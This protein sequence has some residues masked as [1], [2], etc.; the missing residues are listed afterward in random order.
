MRASD[1]SGGLV[2]RGVRWDLSELYVGPD[3]PRLREHLEEAGRLAEELARRF[4]GRIATGEAR[5]EDLAEALVLYERIVERGTR[6]GFYA[7]LLFA[8]DTEND[9]ARQLDAWAREG[10]ADVRERTLFLELE[11]Q[12]M[13]DERLRDMLGSTRLAR[14]R[15]YLETCVRHRPHTLTEA[16]ERILNRKALTS[17]DAFVQLYDELAGSL[18]FELEVDGE[19]RTLTD[20]EMMA[21]LHHRDATVRRRALE[22]YLETW[23]HHELVLTSTFNNLLLDHRIESDLRRFPTPIAQRHLENDVDPAV[24]EAMLDSVERHYGDVQRYFRLK[25]RLLGIAEP[26]VSD[27]YAPVDAGE[28]KIP[29][30]EAR[31]LVLDAFA[32]F[33]GR[34]AD[35]GRR[36][37][38]R[39]WIDAEIRPSKRS[40]AFCATHAPGDHPWV[41]SSYAATPRDV[42][43][44]AHELGH[45][46]HAILSG[47][48]SLLVHDAPLVLAET[49]SVFAEWLLA[50][51]LLEQADS[52]PLRIRLIC[53][54]LDEAY[55]TIFRQ[56]A[57][58]RFE[59]AAHRARRQRRLTAE[60]VGGLWVA[61]QEK[62]FGDALRVPAI[63]RW[64]WIYVP[65]FLHLP[66]YCYAYSFGDLLVL[67]LFERYRAE[68]AAFVPGYLDLLARGGSD[69]PARLLGRLG[70]D[71]SDPAFWERGLA[72]VRRWIDEL[73][74]TAQEPTR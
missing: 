48:C 61:E 23:K 1:H 64:G 66:F 37:F 68:G 3:D 20:S 5:E 25:S 17:S 24:V 14:W 22:S 2:A 71:L 31:R 57:M 9:R 26:A 19:R 4:R 28:E 65:H 70:I 30:D 40:G 35:L 8:A 45:G 67:A 60:E 41:L 7:S 16:E 62:L 18:R 36:F 52:R 73:E 63:Y 54:A 29:F 21:L 42:S 12:R 27:V 50:E 55:G 32:R 6:P 74:Q 34:F 56:C 44:L 33:D 43:T 39:G 58:T 38:E 47:G 53:D 46:I 59:L 51:H 15:H 72:A 13:P 10:W 11:L 69:R 49:A